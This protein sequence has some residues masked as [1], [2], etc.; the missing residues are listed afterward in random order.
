[1]R[2]YIA[3]KFENVDEVRALQRKLKEGGHTVTF[4]WT[5][6]NDEPL[7]EK[8]LETALHAYRRKCALLDMEGVRSA[9]VLVLIPCPAM[10][11][12]GR[13]AE[14]GAAGVLHKPI[15]VVGECYDSVFLYLPTVRRVKDVG[16][17]FDAFADLIAEGEV[18][19]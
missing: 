12:W 2:V 13:Y 9:D 19:A 6:Y 16:D 11:G 4:D 8:G 17:L 5:A 3:S 7:K 15:I 18:A 14:F 10:G 1:M